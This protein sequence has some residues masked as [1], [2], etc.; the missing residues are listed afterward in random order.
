MMEV[1]R[2]AAGDSNGVVSCNGYKNGQKFP[3]RGEWGDKRT[4]KE[5]VR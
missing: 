3:S 1:K 2:E 4:Q 5:G